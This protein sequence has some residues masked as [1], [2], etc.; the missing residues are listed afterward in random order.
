MT[1]RRQRCVNLGESEKSTLPRQKD[2]HH[3]RPMTPSSRRWVT[4]LTQER[5][6]Y[7]VDGHWTAQRRAHWRAASSHL[8]RLCG[9]MTM[10]SHLTYAQGTCASGESKLLATWGAEVHAAATGFQVGRAKSCAGKLELLRNR[11]STQ[12]AVK[13]SLCG[14]RTVSRDHGATV[15][16]AGWLCSSRCLAVRPGLTA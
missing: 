13:Y 5:P 8:L 15:L 7:S 9:Y 12:P 2:T 6:A 10:S 3:Q 1:R 14:P 11:R 4:R 16:G